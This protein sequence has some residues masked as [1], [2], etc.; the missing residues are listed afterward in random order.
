MQSE[1]CC[2]ARNNQMAFI[3]D[4]MNIINSRG[5]CRYTPPPPPPPPQLLAWTHHLITGLNITGRRHWSKTAHLR[6]MTVVYIA[7]LTLCQVNA[8][9]PQAGWR[10][11]LQTRPQTSGHHPIQQGRGS[12]HT[13]C[14]LFFFLFSFFL[15]F[16]CLSHLHCPL[17]LLLSSLL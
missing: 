14:I 1:A 2:K 7:G 17:F 12:M 3:V 10:Q 13:P 16:L 11:S 4:V 9:S 8:K 15:P 5:G 6:T